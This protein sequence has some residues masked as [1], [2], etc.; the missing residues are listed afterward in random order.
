MYHFKR[1]AFYNF[2]AISP[3][4]SQWHL[5][6]RVVSITQS[7]IISWK[8]VHDNSISGKIW[9]LATTITNSGDSENC[10]G[11][12]VCS[13]T[14][15]N[16]FRIGVC[17]AN[18][19]WVVVLIGLIWSALWGFGFFDVVF[20]WVMMM[21]FDCVVLVLGFALEL[22]IDWVTGVFEGCF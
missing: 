20:D 1:W 18:W 9:R 7:L 8:T 4:K 16:C 15:E 22:L 13:L 5:G 19:G 14:T 3:Q 2:R 11:C 17:G 21:C 6:S 12:N 10:W